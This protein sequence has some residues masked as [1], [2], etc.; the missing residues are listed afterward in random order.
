V[1]LLI[2]MMRL[3]CEKSMP[4]FM[5]A[6]QVIR[7]FAVADLVPGLVIVCFYNPGDPVFRRCQLADLLQVEHRRAWFLLSFPHR[8]LPTSE[9]PNRKY[10][11]S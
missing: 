4:A 7:I 5:E 3:Q 10:F 11:Y 8:P 6:E 1:L 9:L 2:N